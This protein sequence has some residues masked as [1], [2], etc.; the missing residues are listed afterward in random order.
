MQESWMSHEAPN[1]GSVWRWLAIEY[2][3]RGH[4]SRQS[5]KA[6]LFRNCVEQAFYALSRRLCDRPVQVRTSTGAVQPLALKTAA[7]RLLIPQVVHAQGAADTLDD[8]LESKIRHWLEGSIIEPDELGR[9][10]ES[11]YGEIPENKI[12]VGT[13]A[14]RDRNTEGVFYTPS[15]LVE[16]LCLQAIS[17]LL[18]GC[19]TLE[20]VTSLSIVD[21]AMGGGRFL[22]EAAAHII[23]KIEDLQQ[24]GRRDPGV[25]AF[26]SIYGVDRDPL[27]V[28]VTRLSLWFAGGA[29]PAL[30]RLLNKQIVCGDALTGEVSPNR[31]Q[32]RGLPYCSDGIYWEQ[33]FPTVFGRERSG[34]DVVIGNP[35]WGKVKAE[36]KRFVTASINDA[37]NLQGAE[38]R[39]FVASHPERN[40][41]DGG[42][43]AWESH[44]DA[45]KS[46][47]ASLRNIFT[48]S[49]GIAGRGDAD[50]YKYFMARCIQ[51]TR[52][53]GITALIVPSA[54]RNT[55]GTASLRSKYL[56]NGRFLF[57]TERTNRRRF[58]PIH[59]MFRFISFAFHKGGAS[60]I[61]NMTFLDGKI[62]GTPVQLSL[63]D[64]RCV[65]GDSL[66]I[67][68]VRNQ[69]E[70]DLLKRL[71]RTHERLDAPGV[72]SV[73]F[74]REIDMTNAS[75][76]FVLSSKVSGKDGLV[77][78]PLYEGRMVD[79]FDYA[80]K[81]Y[82]GGAGRM[83]E[84]R[85]LPLGN[86]VVR[87]HYYLPVKKDDIKIA[88]YSQPRA[89]FCDITGHANRRTVL[90]AIIPGGTAS[91]NKVPTCQFQP[92]NDPRLH[93]LWVAIANS[94]TIDWLVRRR[95]STT[96]NFFHLYAIPFPKLALNSPVAERL[97]ALS[98]SLVKI[99]DD[100]AKFSNWVMLNGG[101]ASPA[102]TDAL[103]RSDIINEIDAIVYE[104][105]GLT[106]TEIDIIRSDFSHLTNGVSKRSKLKG[107][108]QIKL[109][110]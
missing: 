30:A 60:G 33:A 9:A 48:E 76:R 43:A 87:P 35:P 40:I 107:S 20:S 65:S 19:S 28:D 13:R 83:A 98:A 14:S 73:K 62:D 69:D 58:F 94:L 82:I 78:L 51:L 90:A 53:D 10:F 24:H 23:K 26:A 46:Y 1:F 91:G 27:A 88:R 96:L 80:A 97:I 63:A 71:Y 55:E 50:L 106:K 81:E 68:E 75:G 108:A 34:F 54:F 74:V 99:D 56:D 42:V 101:N 32:G 102:I 45:M 72:W 57:F 44:S 18:L 2:F 36:F 110:A 29:K 104:L 41:Q 21:P 61:D 109:A 5:E 86:K 70:F 39:K 15:F 105:F 7:L 47:A 103:V 25:L 59:S 100:N 64:L 66:L 92:I 8:Q 11:L 79:Q 84:W 67:P 49:D 16:E 89:A 22:L 85:N 31:P 52:T 95:I 6:A 77:Y 37:S 3:K 12:N 4:S 38:L 93:L 17:P